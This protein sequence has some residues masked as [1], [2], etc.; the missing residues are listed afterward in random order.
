MA[1]TAKTYDATKIVLGPADLWLNVAVPSSGARLTV[2]ADLTPDA[3][4]NPSCVH[5]GMTAAGCTFEYKPTVQDFESDELTAPHLSRI[6]TEQAT[7]KGE[8]LQVFDWNILEK[9]SVGGTKTINTSTT[10]GYHS[11]TV[12]GLSTV[13]TFPIA[14][15]GQDINTS[16]LYW[17]IQ[18]YKTYNKSGFTFQVTRKDQSK[19][20]FEFS[21]LAIT[22]RTAGD[23]VANYWKSL[24]A[25]A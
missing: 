13:S 5:L 20:P 11:M 21:G 8:F 1:G 17:V 15:I 6:I 12:G 3:T 23:Q 25:G 19:A 2:A 18:L 7:I 10:S 9:M 16:T 4:A 24:V 14:L 22:T